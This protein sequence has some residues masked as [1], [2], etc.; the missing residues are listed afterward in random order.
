MIYPLHSAV[1]S[2]SVALDWLRFG[3]VDQPFKLLKRVSFQALIKWPDTGRERR[4]N[5]ISL[6]AFSK[7]RLLVIYRSF[8]I[9]LF[10]Y[11]ICSLPF[12]L[13]L[14]ADYPE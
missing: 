11:I 2:I 1:A 4:E 14:R 3:G 5:L 6:L 13:G 7:K 8:S 12:S 10:V 9:F